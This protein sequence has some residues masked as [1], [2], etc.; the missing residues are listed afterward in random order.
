MN[1]N[2]KGAAVDILRLSNSSQKRRSLTGEL[3]QGMTGKSAGRDVF[4]KSSTSVYEMYTVPEKKRGGWLSDDMIA[5]M[6]N[7][8]S[9]VVQYGDTFRCNGVEFKAEQIPPVDGSALDEVKAVDNKINFGK[10]QYFKY[11]SPDGKE[12]YLYTDDYSA[13]FIVSEM[14]RGAP[15]DRDLNRYARYWRNLMAKDPIFI[16]LEYSVEEMKQY[17]QEAGMETG[18]FTVQ[19][20]EKERTHYFTAGK[21]APPVISKDRYDFHYHCLAE[22]GNLLREY[23]EGDI[24]KIGG[25]EYALSAS[26][27]LDIPYG[28]DIFDIEYPSNYFYGK[29]VE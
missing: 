6:N 22:A 11:V 2:R 20:G 29:R 19:M 14:L 18:F 7:D 24:F 12:H 1:V 23:E 25:K 4:I 15:Y 3:L 5:D 13:G 28:A 27:T 8:I 21:T 10:N 17:M 9:K 16:T 26:H